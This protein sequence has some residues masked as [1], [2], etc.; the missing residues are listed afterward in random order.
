MTLF[1][2]PLFKAYALPSA[3]KAG[4]D[5]AYWVPLLAAYAGARPS[6]PCQLWCDDISEGPG[7]LVIEFREHAERKQKLKGGKVSCALSLSTM[8]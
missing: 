5:A 4:A 6:E 7:G 2:A 1:D 3:T 8:N